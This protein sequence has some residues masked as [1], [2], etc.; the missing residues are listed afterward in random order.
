ML[1]LCRR[2]LEHVLPAVEQRPS[3]GVINAGLRAVEA[4]E[5]ALLAGEG[6][7]A[8]SVAMVEGLEETRVGEL[9][10][11]DEGSAERDGERDEGEGDGEVVLRGHT[12]RHDS[13]RC[14]DRHSRRSSRSL[15]KRIRRRT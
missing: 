10:V 14:M 8:G 3:G 15:I 4:F 12:A 6:V 5:G 9:A 2:E 11:D 13:R 1:K 7:D